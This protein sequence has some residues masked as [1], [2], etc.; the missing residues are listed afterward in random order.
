MNDAHQ[1]AA[2]PFDDPF[3]DDGEFLP[4]A[5]AEAAARPAEVLPLA[6]ERAPEPWSRRR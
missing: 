3:A 1:L 2:D 6:R 4:L 5:E